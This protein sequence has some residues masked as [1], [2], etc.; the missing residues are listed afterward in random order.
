MKTKNINASL[1]FF[2]AGSVFLFSCGKETEYIQVEGESAVTG[3][4]KLIFDARYGEADFKLN[5]SYD[6]KASGA[7]GTIDLK[8]EFNQLRYWIS[9]VSL[10]TATGEEVKIQDSYYLV[11]ENI[12][13]PVQGGSHNKQY[14][15]NKRE[16]IAI[17]HIP[18]GEYKAIR[19]GVGVDF[20]YNDNLSLRAGELS[21]LNGMAFEEWM[22]FTSY[23]FF[24]LNG[25]MTWEKPAPQAAVSQTFF[26]DYASNNL[27]SKKEIQFDKN[28]IIDAKQIPSVAMEVD[29]KKL[30]N[31]DDPWSNNV[32]SQT[33]KALMIRLKDNFLNT[34][35]TLKN[36]SS[37]PVK[38]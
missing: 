1:I 34:A 9:N 29:V 37:V 7:N 14:P 17:E 25:K 5:T 33:K 27:Y 12:E 2:F 8:Y 6:Y 26:W 36:T 32:I 24:V 30:I 20:R 16:E 18:S 35:I 19:F 23:K 21:S 3:K 4:A 38:N 28:I 11:E 15:A 31:V 10:I 13:I 22:W